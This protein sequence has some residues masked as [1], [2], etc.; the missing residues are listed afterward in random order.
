MREEGRLWETTATQSTLP[1]VP[2]GPCRARCCLRPRRKGREGGLPAA[3]C[4]GLGA[5]MQQPRPS[6]LRLTSYK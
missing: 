5:G 3:H 4:E 6:S 2:Q 1:Q